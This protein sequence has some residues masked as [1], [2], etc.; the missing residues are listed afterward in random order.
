[1]E[2]RA[3]GS[4]GM[5]VSALGI[6]CWSFGGGSGDYWGPQDE[7]DAA[8]VVSAALDCGINYFDTA[9]L[10]NDGCSEES[11]GR[12]LAGRRH[13]ALIGTKVSPGHV[14]PAALRQ[15]CE[16]SLRRLGTDYID[17]YMVHWPITGY[18]IEDAFATLVSLRDEGKIRTIGV[19]NHGV[20][21]LGDV[22]STGAPIA[23]NQLY[24]NLLSRA[25]EVEILPLCR[26]LSIGVI[27]YMPLQQGLL[28]GKYRS[29]DE[30][31]WVRTRTRHFASTRRGARHGEAGAEA[32]VFAA[33]DAIR[34]LSQELRVPMAQLALVWTLAQP[35][36]SCV[37]AGARTAEQVM[38]NFAAA[39]LTLS[40][41]VIARLDELT[42][43]TLRKLGANPDYWESSE[44][45]RIR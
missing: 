24:Y 36:I 43:P 11:L 17:I 14:E 30:M 18:S 38:E 33:L 21:Q 26:Q 23:V 20:Q 44:N 1:M 31:P 19:S 12:A 42:E 37:L 8:S 7:R 28:T 29:A 15:H 3:C 35:G 5:V 10:Y 16:A 27:G 9:E 13:H 32:E 22:A 25:I 6:G 34:G 39:Q 2:R 4:S 41:D 45:S 40:P